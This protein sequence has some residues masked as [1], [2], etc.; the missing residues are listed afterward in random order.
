MDMD[1]LRAT[2]SVLNQEFVRLQQTVDSV[3]KTE[4]ELRELLLELEAA[5]R[6]KSEH[7]K[8]YPRSEG[9]GSY[10]SPVA[11]REEVEKDW[12]ECLSRFDRAVSRLVK[13]ARTQRLRPVA[14]DPGSHERGQAPRQGSSRRGP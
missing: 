5:D 11:S 13:F 12:H 7:F 10:E 9:G 3:P 14:Q 2:L 1:T 4:G 8:R 6:N